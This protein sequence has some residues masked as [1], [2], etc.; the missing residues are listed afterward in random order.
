M[1]WINFCQRVKFLLEEKVRN[2]WSSDYNIWTHCLAQ[3]TPPIVIPSM[4]A[5]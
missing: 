2:G 5:T 1:S 3:L 4:N